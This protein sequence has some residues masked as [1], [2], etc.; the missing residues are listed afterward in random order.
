MKLTERPWVKHV[1]AAWQRLQVTNGNLYAAAITYFS[2]LALFP[3]IL[4]GVSIVGFVLSSHPAAL[5]TLFDKIAENAPGQ[6]GSTLKDAVETAIDQRTSV[7]IIGLVGVLIT[8]LG[9]IGNL[10]ASLDAV[11]KRTPPKQNPV[12]QR[13]V[14]LLILAGLGLGILV[15]LGLTAGW[16]AFSHVVL[17]TIGLDG[18]PGMGT[19]LGAVGI[20]V[21]IVADAVIF[22]FVLV[23][24]PQVEVPVRIG[25]KGALL[26]AAGF[27][28]LKIAGTY[29][30]AASSHSATAGPFASIIAVL[31]W[32]QLVTRF[33]LF[34]CAWTAELTVGEPVAPPRI[35]VGGAERAT[36]QQP[37]LSPAAVE[38][39]RERRLRTP[40]AHAEP[41]EIGRA[42]V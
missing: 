12:M 40:H 30:I 28:I 7:G 37:A 34:C 5:H 1:W 42:H 11:W 18:I 38:G 39:L 21:T 15:S 29:T 31:V 33:M 2:F 8:G 23:R 36:A 41:G 24:I 3:L 4:L 14:N 35:E 16:A 20:L 17:K 13:V 26:A 32:I 9:W 27:E 25:I 6:F 10:R 19:A 22:F